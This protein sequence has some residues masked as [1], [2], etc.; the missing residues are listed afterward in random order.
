[1]DPWLQ[2][3]HWT[4]SCISGSPELLTFNKPQFSLQSK[5][6]LSRSFS[7]FVVSCSVKFGYTDRKRAIWGGEEQR[8]FYISKREFTSGYH[9]LKYVQP[10]CLGTDFKK[11]RR[12]ILIQSTLVA[13]IPRYLSMTRRST[14]G[15]CI[16]QFWS[17]ILENK[18]NR[19]GWLDHLQ[20]LNIVQWNWSRVKWLGCRLCWRTWKSTT[21][22]LQSCTMTTNLP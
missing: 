20:R 15:F 19:M 16:L 1:M 7:C 18:K 5:L 4:A 22:Q 6:N 10:W 11:M 9:S 12:Y 8:I 13:L 17:N 3:S 21:Y 14:T 2:V